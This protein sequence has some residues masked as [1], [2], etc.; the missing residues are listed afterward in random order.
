LKLSISGDVAL[1]A[2]SEV[3]VLIADEQSA[4]RR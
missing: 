2:R 4:L 1:I 3:K